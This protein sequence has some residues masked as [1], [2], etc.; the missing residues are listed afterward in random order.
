[1]D[2]S[3]SGYL[4]LSALN[5]KQGYID[6]NLDAHFGNQSLYDKWMGGK[7]LRE[8]Q[9]LFTTEAPMGNVAQVP[10]NKGYILS[11]RTIAFDVHEEKISDDF[12]AVL[13]SSPKVFT[14]LTNLSSGG[15]AKGVS[16]RTLSELEVIIPSDLA[17]QSL[18]SSYCLKMD[19][20]I[21]LH[22]RKLDNVKMLKKSLLQKLFPKDGEKIPELRFPGFTDDW[23]QRNLGELIQIERGGSP[24]PIEQYI[25]SDS[26][27]LNWIKI[28][29]AP[30]QGNYITETSEK[31]KPSG[32]S[33]TRQVIPGDLIL[34]NSMSFGRPYI[35][36]IEGCIHDGWLLIR[37]T[38]EKFDKL[39]LCNLLGSP[40]MIEQ[41]KSM[42]AGSTVNNLNKELVSSAKVP[43]P[44]I[45][46]QILIGAYLDNFDSLISLHQRKLD[47]LKELKKGLL[48]QMFV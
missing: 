28:G 19:S 12:L 13:L 4:A 32:L 20:L 36:A 7:E 43:V 41:Y 16:Q 11:Q 39:F 37:D 10:D 9:V 35:M 24:R 3:E 17:E 47:H 8:G 22:Q 15:T 31:I 40:M 26:N 42:A 23:E 45:T 1:M 29:D 25:T 46:E 18:I 34:S 44:K 5:V 2:W 38:N 33:K 21:S 48:Q 6:F 14:E 30:K 27:G